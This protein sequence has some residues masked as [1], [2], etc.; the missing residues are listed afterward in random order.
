[1]KKQKKSGKI[2]SIIMSVCFV[3]VGM[4]CGI[5]IGDF[6]F[7]VLEADISVWQKILM[8]M[9]AVAAIMIAAFGQ[10]ILHEAG[11]LV[12]GL[13]SG[14]RFS[15][16]RI[17]SFML[18]KEK[19]K[20]KCKKMSLAG[21]GG[22]C[23]MSPP[24]MVDGK[25]PFVLFNL[26]G[27]LMNLAAAVLSFGLYFLCRGNEVLSLFLLM[28]GIIGIGF[29]LVNGIPMQSGMISNDGYNAKELGKMPEALRAFWVQ[30]KVVE[31]SSEGVRLKDMPEEW[32]RMPDE[33]G[34]KN[35]MVSTIAV[36]CE[37]RL[38]D[39]LEI[40]KAEKLID[41]LLSS[42][43]TVLGIYWNLLIC[44]KICCAL[45]RQDEKT[46]V[47]ALLNKEQKTFMKQ[48][49]N[50][51]TVIRTEYVYAMLG[52]QDAEETAKVKA[53]FEKCAK[54]HPYA[55]DIESERELMKLAEERNNPS[56]F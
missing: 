51:P 23:L 54:T 46:D 40:D 36:F 28:M 50:F 8:F 38:M 2:G 3:V 47:E 30:M 24:D 41:E 42:E 56:E 6:I 37:N 45:L 20:L 14:Y 21:T 53:R 17:G 25:I 22:Q 35:S 15:S 13:I 9:G 34:M 48:M 11:H 12:A 55:V 26:G 43:K 31:K 10:I 1:M 32:F 4:V 39:K 18:V 52:K 44:D 27:C 16:F 33:N 19:G 7:P 29:A 49:K 5:A